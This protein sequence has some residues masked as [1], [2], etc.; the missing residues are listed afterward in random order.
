MKFRLLLLIGILIFVSCSDEEESV[1]VFTPVYFTGKPNDQ[2]AY[3]GDV[4]VFSA[5]V[6]GTEPITYQWYVGDVM[7]ANTPQLFLDAVPEN[8]GKSIWVK[9]SNKT[10]DSTY[11]DSS[12]SG[13]VNLQ[14]LESYT[15]SINEYG[16]KV[17][18]TDSIAGFTMGSTSPRASGDESPVRNVTFTNKIAMDS[19]PVSEAEYLHVMSSV[20]SYMYTHYDLPENGSASLPV[21]GV[22]WY[23][24]ILYANGRSELDSLKPYYHYKTNLVLDSVENTVLRLEDSVL[25]R[26]EGGGFVS[27]KV[28]IVD[29][30]AYILPKENLKITVPDSGAADQ[31]II[32]EV[33]VTAQEK[34]RILPNKTYLL[35]GVSDTLLIDTVV[36]QNVTDSVI[37]DTF[38]SIDLYGVDGIEL[39][40]TVIRN[41]TFLENDSIVV[42]T[43]VFAIDSLDTTFAVWDSLVFDTLTGKDGFRL[44]TEAEWEFAVRQYTGSDYYFPDSLID[45]YAWYSSNEITISEA[46]ESGQKFPNRYGLYDMSGNVWEWC[47]DYYGVY[48]DSAL[49]DPKGPADGNYRVRR[50]GSYRDSKIYLRSTQ[51]GS[52]KM[53][54]K[55]E[56][57]GFR[58]VR[59]EF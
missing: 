13:A 26:L 35:T 28:T 3:E 24:A 21:T 57:V 50:G 40:D 46:Q 29:S 34:I 1:D 53:S 44:P 45:S 4:A 10:N 36:I 39:G 9:V 32:M 8:E 41:K 11:S 31:N 37:V 42:D 43:V 56:R 52:G 54:E 15:P 27:Y 51:R 38:Y 47:Y 55:S 59:T 30:F 19:F 33:K 58:T 5:S 48:I 49:V 7:V 12:F 25:V 16:M 23:D 6:R 20:E 17:I 14:L 2:Y 18:P 22:N